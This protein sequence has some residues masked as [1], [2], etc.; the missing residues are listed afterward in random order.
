M[1]ERPSTREDEP[2]RVWW[3]SCSSVNPSMVILRRQCWSIHRRW[4]LRRLRCL[5]R[6]S[7]RRAR[8]LPTIGSTHAPPRTGGV[9]APSLDRYERAEDSAES[10]R[11]NPP[12]KG[13]HRS[14][15]LLLRQLQ[16]L[17]TV[18]ADG[19]CRTDSALSARHSLRSFHLSPYPAG[20][21]ILNLDTSETVSRFGSSDVTSL[22]EKTLRLVTCLISRGKFDESC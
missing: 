2:G 1:G 22:N 14:H 9:V 21:G 18:G 3:S 10:P 11:R 19:A 13:R 15:Q 20:M 6:S 8:P 4:S 5:V 17:Q 12:V 7:I 16:M